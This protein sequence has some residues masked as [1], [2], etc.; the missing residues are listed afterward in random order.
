MQHQKMPKG[1]L[2]LLFFARLIHMQPLNWQWQ[3]CRIQCRF[4]LETKWKSAQLSHLQIYWKL[5]LPHLY[6]HT[7]A[8]V[9][10]L[11]RVPRTTMLLPRWVHNGGVAW[12]PSPGSEM[13]IMNINTSY[14][15]LHM[16][17]FSLWLQHLSVLLSRTFFGDLFFPPLSLLCSVW[18][19]KDAWQYNS[20]W[21]AFSLCSLFIFSP[22]PLHKNYISPTCY[23][24]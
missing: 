24:P 14:T 4:I 11:H 22:A 10:T 13:L 3:T 5:L 6:M 15:Q 20:A 23:T 7:S 18:I 16:H 2:T 12:G 19:H 17:I 8:W 21:S 1:R 9:Y